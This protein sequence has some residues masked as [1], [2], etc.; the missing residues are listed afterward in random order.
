MYPHTVPYPGSHKVS[1]FLIQRKDNGNL[2][3]NGFGSVDF[4]ILEDLVEYFTNHTGGL[5]H[6]LCVPTQ[7]YAD[8]IDKVIPML[9]RNVSFPVF[10]LDKRCIRYLP[11]DSFAEDNVKTLL[12]ET[13][14]HLNV[15][16]HVRLIS[17]SVTKHGISLTDPDCILFD[18]Y[19][20]PYKQIKNCEVGTRDQKISLPIAYGSKTANTFGVIHRDKEGEI[21]YIALAEYED[22]GL[23]ITKTINKFRSYLV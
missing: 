10:I 23:T 12:N 13:I 6:P 22:K 3:I 19:S 21:I 20:V 8:R 11:L 9:L 15:E 14:C 2:F 16:N 5:P 17:M 4:P 1:N 18:T 7:P